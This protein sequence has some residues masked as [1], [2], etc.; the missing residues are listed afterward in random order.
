M[1]RTLRIF[2]LVIALGSLA[3]PLAAQVNMPN[4]KEVSGKALPVNDIPAGSITVRVIRGSLDKNLP[5]VPVTITVDGKPRTIKTNEAGRV[6]IHDLKRGAVVKATATVDGESLQSEDITIGESGIRVMLVA[7]DPELAAREA[8]NQRLAAGPAVKGAVVFGPESRIIA[9][10]NG[11]RL[12][13]FY[14][15]EVVNTARTPVDIGGPLLFDLPVGARG[16]GM[17]EGAAPTA[18][19]SGAHV[20]VTG[21]FAPGTTAVHV[22]F[23]MPYSGPQMRLTQKWPIALPQVRLLVTQ[24]GG[25]AVRSPQAPTLREVSDQGQRLIL[26]SGPAL[27][28][29]ETFTLEI[30]GLPHHPLWPRNLALGAAGLIVVLGLWSAFGPASR[31][32]HA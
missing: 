32:R 31:R 24:I 23:E 19:V 22:G 9:E 25:L 7:T 30:D 8:E 4:L 13:V 16:A 29:R 6:E 11:D 12:N 5:S 26:G 3:A 27:A 1:M 28:P 14:I 21:P 10:M 2:L 20:T 18:K 17:L 15:L